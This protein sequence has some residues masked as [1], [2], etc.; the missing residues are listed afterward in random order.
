LGKLHFPNEDVRKTSSLVGG[1]IFLRYINPGICTPDRCPHLQLFLFPSPTSNL[2]PK[3]HIAFVALFVSAW[4][5]SCSLDIIDF[6]C[7]ASMRRNLILIAKVIQNLSN[8][9]PFG[10]KEAF[11]QRLNNFIADNTDTIQVRKIIPL[12]SQFVTLSLSLS[13]FPAFSSKKKKKMII[14][15]LNS[16]FI[17]TSQKQ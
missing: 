8:D 2:K 7:T 14:L 11:M 4:C 1:L 3:S 10:G 16:P 6:Q 12:R 17:A 9:V 15:V 5:G 13:L